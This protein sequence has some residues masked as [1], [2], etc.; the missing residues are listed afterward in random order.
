MASAPGVWARM[1]PLCFATNSARAVA[2]KGRAEIG[3]LGRGRGELV[4]YI[5]MVITQLGA[6]QFPAQKP[7]YWDTENDCTAA[8]T[9]IDPT[10]PITCVAVPN[11]GRSPEGK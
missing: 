8:S 1:T 4:K 6:H 9:L 2:Q 11:K 3:D 10:Y 7:I 5:L